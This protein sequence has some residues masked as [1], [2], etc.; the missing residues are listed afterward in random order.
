S[1][2]ALK[3]GYGFS[4]APICLLIEEINRGEI[5]R[6][7]M[8]GTTNKRVTLNLVYPNIDTAG[9]AAKR[10]ESLLLAAVDEYQRKFMNC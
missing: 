3:R 9:P 2:E 5:V 6:L 1:R 8:E 7:Q 10:L 4:W